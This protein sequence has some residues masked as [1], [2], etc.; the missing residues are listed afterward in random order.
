MFM[1]IVFYF[2]IFLFVIV[3][4]W[5]FMVW[6]RKTM[7]DAVHRNLLDLEDHID[8]R[9]Q[10]R[11]FA[12]R[13]FFHGHFNGTEVTINFS[14][15]KKGNKRRTYV[16]ISYSVSSS[17]SFSVS[18]KSWLLEQQADSLEDFLEMQ[19]SGGQTMAIRPASSKAVKELSVNKKF[20]KILNEQ[21]DM[22]YIFAGQSGLLYEYITEEVI[23]ATE[24]DQLLARL[25]MLE[26]LKEVL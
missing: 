20:L 6:I 24:P 15:E 14:S 8:G 10:R 25:S 21:A 11:G 4:L 13:P 1:Q 17:I 23:K 16:D 9:V 3:A 5:F 18:E 2:F 12:G 7:W 19:T 22:A 26:H